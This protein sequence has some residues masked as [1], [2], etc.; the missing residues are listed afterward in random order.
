MSHNPEVKMQSELAPAVQADIIADIARCIKATNSLTIL[1]HQQPDGDAVGS[2]LGLRLALVKL[3]KQVQV[4]CP[5]P[6]PDKYQFLPEAETILTEVS[7]QPQVVVAVDAD[8]WSRL[9][10]LEAVI[11]DANTTILIDHHATNAGGADLD[12]IDPTAAA[13]AVQIYHLL[14]ALDVVPD[15]DIATCLYCGLATDTGFFTFENTTP[16]ALWI[17]AEL[18]AAGANPHQI[19]QQVATRLSLAAAILRGRALASLQTAA[20]GRLVYATLTPRDFALA[21]ADRADTEGIIDT[22]KSVAGAEVVVLF[23]ADSSGCC[24]ISLRSPSLDVAHIAAQLGG[25]GHQAAAG[26]EV[27]GPLPAVTAKVINSIQ[28]ALNGKA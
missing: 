25:G 5:N 1:T 12:Y 26:A 9:G 2:S 27:A 19:A 18:V 24:H 21:G 15:A 14:L 10:G 20:D 6:V 7:G 13:S 8:N 4:A 16:E 28:Q 17:A 3:G 23:K 11:Q 22:L